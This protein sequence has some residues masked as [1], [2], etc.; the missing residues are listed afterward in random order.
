MLAGWR[1]MSVTVQQILS[2]AKRLVTRLREHDNSA[3]T[4]LAQTQTLNKT[5]ENMKQ[6]NE[7]LAELNMAANQRPRSALILNIQQENRHIREL[8]QENRE[9]R[10]LLEEHQSTL[11]LIMTKYR[12]QVTKLVQ[13]NK[14]EEACVK[15]D[16][17]KE[18]QKS[19]DK[20][21]EMAAVM[22]H[23]V[24]IDDNSYCQEREKLTQLMTENKGLRELLKISIAA[25]SIRCL[26]SPETS[27]KSVQTDL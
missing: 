8:Q 27:D 15:L 14:V 23:A 10:S 22:K 12:Q 24:E 17:S 25:G 11:E 7:E 2:D 21:C 20:I 16:N 4:L 9:L 5:V 6:Y 3:D 26:T 13:T 18:L 1:T 19:A